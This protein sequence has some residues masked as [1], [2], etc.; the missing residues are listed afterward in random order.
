[1]EPAYV[2]GL[3]HRILKYYPRTEGLSF[4]DV[5]CANGEYL[6][7]AQ[8]LKMKPLAGIEVDEEAKSRA[9]PHGPISSNLDELREQYDVV[10][11]KNVLT[12]IP[13]FQ[14]FFQKLLKRTKPGG[15]LFL[16]VLNQFGLVAQVKKAFGKPG[17]LRAPFVVNG[18]SKKALAELVRRNNAALIWMKTTYVGSDLLPYRRNV[19]LLIRGRL[20]Q[21]LAAGSMIAADITVGTP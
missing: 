5:G 4:L 13:D 12:N 17:I 19:R 10:Q 15:V 2:R 7:A 8:A 20:G 18:F 14:A 3:R 16:D 9:A 6:R 21:L 11:C 1:M